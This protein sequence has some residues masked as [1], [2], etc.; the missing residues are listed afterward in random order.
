MHENLLYK[1]KCI[2]LYNVS[3]KDTKLFKDLRY[4]NEALV[5]I[6]LE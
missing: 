6:M 4:D 1:K 5:G 2:E 3:D